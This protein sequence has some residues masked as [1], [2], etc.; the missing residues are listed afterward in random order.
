MSQFAGI[1]LCG[2]RSSRM[3]LDKANLSIAGKALLARTVKTLAEVAKPI[4]V[5]A[6]ADQLLPPLPTDTL[7]VRD[8]EPEK[9]PLPAFARALAAI[10]SDCTCT[11]LLACD[12]PFLTV[13]FL[14]FLAERPTQADAVVPHV[15]G[16]WHPLTALYRQAVRSTAE[17]ILASGR[18]RMLDL[19]DA[20]PVDRIDAEELRPIDPELHCLRNVN[21][22][23]DYAAALRELG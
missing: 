11:Y 20:I 19:I 21:T 10:P 16:L 5:A 9:G 7:I 2:G 22:P 6:A 14:R 18:R 15:A 4:V 3:G 23:E 1:V 13:Q 8:F 17:R 12:L